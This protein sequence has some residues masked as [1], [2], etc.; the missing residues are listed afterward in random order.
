MGFI[1]V[2]NRVCVAMSRAKIGLYVIGN[3]EMICKKSV[4]WNRIIR[5]A[6]KTGNVGRQLRLSCSRH[7][8]ETPITDL[9]DFSQVYQGVQRFA[10][11]LKWCMLNKLLKT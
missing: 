7:N 8:E 5:Q 1:G 9:M 3:F 11:E 10:N 4:L 6:E 2:D